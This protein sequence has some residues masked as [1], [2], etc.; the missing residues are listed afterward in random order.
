MSKIVTLIVVAA[1]LAGCMPTNPKDESSAADRVVIETDKFSGERSIRTPLYLS[2]QG[3]TDTFPVR[4]SLSAK[5]GPSQP[6]TALLLV[7]KTGTNWGFYN[8]A[9]GEDQ[10]NFA[11]KNLDRNVDVGGGIV[12]TEEYFGL[13]IPLEQLLK[14]SSSDYEIK[15]YGRRD[16]GVFV[17]P[18]TVTRSF[19]QKL[20]EQS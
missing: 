19:L 18:A 20:K 17:V 2:R 13:E 15:V 10:Y 4:I 8:V 3:F 11:F 12:T 5:L 9:R 6:R 7:K 16:S 1:F 14:M